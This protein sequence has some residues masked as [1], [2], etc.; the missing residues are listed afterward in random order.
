MIL[1]FLNSFALDAVLESDQEF[2]QFKRQS[3]SFI[4]FLLLKSFCVGWSYFY[5]VVIVKLLYR[6]VAVSR[7]AVQDFR[8]HDFIPDTM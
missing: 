2:M 3:G 4:W 6:A 7:Y 1:E 8:I 5:F